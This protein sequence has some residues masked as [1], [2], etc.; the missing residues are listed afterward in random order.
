M[1]LQDVATKPQQHEA[2]ENEGLLKYD[3]AVVGLEGV[4]PVGRWY[5][6]EKDEAGANEKNYQGRIADPCL[7][8]LETETRGPVRSDWSRS[9]ITVSAHCY[10]YKLLS[11][12]AVAL[13]ADSLSARSVIVLEF[14]SSLRHSFK[15]SS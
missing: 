6:D 5:G 15:A 10:I 12:F 9:L 7:P 13:H 8:R 1:W 2:G 4:A 14:L 3:E 11:P